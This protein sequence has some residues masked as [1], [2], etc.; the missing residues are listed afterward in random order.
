MTALIPSAASPPLSSLAGAAPVRAG[1]AADRNFGLDLAR[2][3][4]VS[5]VLITHCSIIFL[6]L[7]SLQAPVFVQLSGFFGVELFFVL[8]GFLI[9]RLLFRIAATD[10]TPRGWL[11]F[12][13]RRWLR[14]LPLYFVWLA[15][16]PTALPAPAHL[17]VHLLR[18]GTM[19]QNLAWPMPADHWF[20]ESGAL[21]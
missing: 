15:V 7:A 14:T 5:L 17:A 21:P 2:F 8:S 13:T 20:N 19:T 9:G 4:A 16:I 3:T 18:Y 10:P 1:S 6:S 12:M 11:T